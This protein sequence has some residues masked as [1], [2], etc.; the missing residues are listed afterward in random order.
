MD[1]RDFIFCFSLV[2]VFYYRIFLYSTKII[3]IRKFIFIGVGDWYLVDRLCIVI[4]FSRVIII[5]VNRLY[6]YLIMIKYFY[7]C[8]YNFIIIYIIYFLFLLRFF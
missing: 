1:R 4:F 6:L 2:R 7:K 5:E 8:N 3:M